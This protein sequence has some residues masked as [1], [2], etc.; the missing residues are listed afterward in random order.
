[1]ICRIYHT[2]RRVRTCRAKCVAVNQATTKDGRR[3]FLQLELHVAYQN[4]LYLMLHS[5]WSVGHFSSFAT[6]A[7]LPVGAQPS[8]RWSAAKLR[9]C[10]KIKDNLYINVSVISPYQPQEQQ[11]G[12]PPP[13]P[14]VPPVPPSPGGHDPFSNNNEVPF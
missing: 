11:N 1:M 2:M 9:F 3:T 6:H 10:T 7:G 8:Q 13:V 14:A 5:L 12:T 4:Q